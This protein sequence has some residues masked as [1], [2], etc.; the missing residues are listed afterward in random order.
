MTEY[1]KLIQALRMLS[2]T[3]ADENWQFAVQQA[4][5]EAADAIEDL[6]QIVRRKDKRNTDLHNEGFDVG[7]S[8]GRRDYEPKHGKW[9][10]DSDYAQCSVCGASMWDFC[11]PTETMSVGLPPYC[12]NCGARLE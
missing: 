7:Y 12:P 6:W 10:D 4:M 2:E 1:I 9:S 11:N 5:T 3:Q 8:A